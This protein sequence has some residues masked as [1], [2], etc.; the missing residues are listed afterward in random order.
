MLVAAACGGDGS[1]VAPLVGSVPGLAANGATA[2]V[3][4]ADNAGEGSF[5]A[6]IVEAN[7]DPAI[8]NIE[9]RPGVGTIA[10]AS[11]VVFSGSQALSIDGKRAVI[12]GSGAGGTAFRTTGG[13]DL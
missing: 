13:G 11:G 1:P 2:F 10:L 5:R 7:S 8:K 9:F 6:A 4:N 12:D 3:T